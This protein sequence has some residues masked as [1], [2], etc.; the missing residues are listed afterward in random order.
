MNDSIKK[1]KEV[2][3]FYVLEHADKKYNGILKTQ[4]GAYMFCI[5]YSI[6]SLLSHKTI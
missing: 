6:L 2:P 4:K 1:I 3:V 5:P